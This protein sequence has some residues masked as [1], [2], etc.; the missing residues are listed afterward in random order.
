MGNVV[1]RWSEEI[2]EGVVVVALDY[3][4]FHFRMVLMRLR[5]LRFVALR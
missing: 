3:G 1:V 2:G 5:W 4:M